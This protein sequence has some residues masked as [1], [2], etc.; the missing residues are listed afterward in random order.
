MSKR[1]GASLGTSCPNKQPTRYKASTVHP[2]PGTRLTCLPTKEASTG[3]CEGL[4][5]S[6]LTQAGFPRVARDQ[7]LQQCQLVPH[8]KVHKGIPEAR[9][10][11]SGKET[12]IEELPRAFPRTADWKPNARAAAHPIMREAKPAKGTVHQTTRSQCSLSSKPAW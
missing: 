1:S 3:T 2:G 11:P 12:N 7:K 8:E 10:S 5:P 6:L 9:Q 4:L